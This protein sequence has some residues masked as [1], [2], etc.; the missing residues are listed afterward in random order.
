MKIKKIVLDEMYRAYSTGSTT[1][2]N[3][4][5]LIVAS[6]AI[7]GSCY[8]Y[9]GKDFSEKKVIWEKAGGTM[10]IVEIPNSNGEFLA[11]QEFFPGFNGKTS[12]V[13]H[14]KMVDGEFVVNDF[15]NLPYLHRFDLIEVNG[16]IHFI[17]ASLCSSKTD[18]E[19]WSDPGKIYVGILPKDLSKGMDLKVIYEN[20]THNHGY[21]QST[22]KGQKAGYVTSDEGVFACVA[23]KDEASDWEITHLIDR[24]VSDV[25]LIDI[26]NDGKLE[27]LSIEPFHGKDIY[28]YNEID[29]KYEETFHLDRELEFAHAIA[30]TTILGQPAFVCGIRRLNKELFYLTYNKEKN[31]YDLTMID[32]G[33]GPANI[34]IVN[35]KDQ[36]IILA[37]NNTIHQA[38][39]YII[40]KD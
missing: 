21:Y 12:K 23:P 15:I 17:G 14:V 35:Q 26:N 18:R 40:T 2:D 39:V 6:E 16:V 13:V 36:D 27:I 22:Y 30:G 4:L 31:D 33:C 3:E 8:A 19:D 10:S 7:D 9:T 25:A 29:G 28:I 34:V 32:E 20:L 1:I 11:V 5:Y 38:A 24:K 37:S